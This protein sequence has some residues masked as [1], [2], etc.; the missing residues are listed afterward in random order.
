MSGGEITSQFQ[1]SEI[2]DTDADIL[3]GDYAIHLHNLEA[4]RLYQIS[5]MHGNLPYMYNMYHPKH[6]QRGS[7]WEGPGRP[8]PMNLDHFPQNTS[9]R[10]SI[11]D[12]YILPNNMFLDGFPKYQKGTGTFFPNLVSVF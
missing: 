3:E 1:P 2:R 7:M 11:P 9:G 12:R 8:L 6:V 4:G 10:N 5:Y